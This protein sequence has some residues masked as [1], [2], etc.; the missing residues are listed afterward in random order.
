[1]TYYGYRNCSTC[2]EALKWLKARGI[3]VE[4]RE[5]RET[6]PTP[7]ELAFA[8][9]VLGGERRKLLNTAGVE[10]RSMG[11]RDKIDSLGDTDVFQLIQE[12]GNLCKRPFLIDL[13]HNTALVGFHE[14][15]WQAALGK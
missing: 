9:K 10:F 11:L 12:Q 1:M 4:S 14:A 6:P 13:E 5:I 2:R 15:T 3:E 7:D 8:L